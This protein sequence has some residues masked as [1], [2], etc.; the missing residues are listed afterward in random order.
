MI[1]VYHGEGAGKSSAAL[2]HAVR[3]AAAGKTAYVIQ[4]LKGQ[5]ASDYVLRLDPELKVFRFEQSPVWFDSLSEE[6]QKEERQNILNGLNFAKKVLATDECDLL[7]LDE[8]MGAIGEGI[9]DEADLLSILSVRSQNVDIILT[10]RTL[11]DGV[12]QIADSILNI[13]I[14]K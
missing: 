10:G 9:I 14:E 1:Q 11:P 2:G 5:L 4:F 6:E 7:V 13:M 8:V 12:A 3:A